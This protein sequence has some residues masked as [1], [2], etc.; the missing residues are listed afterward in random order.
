MTACIVFYSTNFFINT[1][2]TA[3]VVSIKIVSPK[4]VFVFCPSIIESITG[5][6]SMSSSPSALLS[7]VESISGVLNSLSKPTWKY[8]F[9]F[10]F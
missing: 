7:G 4:Y 8:I 2:P 10:S 9:Y 5:A 6:S 3:I 1:I